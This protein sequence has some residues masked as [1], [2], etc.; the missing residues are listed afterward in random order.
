M[1]SK[2]GLPLALTRYSPDLE[3]SC[4]TQMVEEIERNE[5]RWRNLT[6]FFF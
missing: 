1:K 6:F 2:P 3:S 4:E 5:I